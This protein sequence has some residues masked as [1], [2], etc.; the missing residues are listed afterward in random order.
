MGFS[1]FT[2]VDQIMSHLTFSGSSTSVQISLYLICGG[3]MSYEPSS[4]RSGYQCL[5]PA[6]CPEISYLRRQPAAREWRSC[7]SVCWNWDSQVTPQ[8]WPT[9]HSRPSHARWAP[10]HWDLNTGLPLP[11]TTSIDHGGNCIFTL[12]WS[13]CSI[14]MCKISTHKIW[15]SF[16]Y[17]LYFLF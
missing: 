10:A 2:N 11:A 7:G 14:L 13:K 9:V 12:C 1:L 4:W 16:M 15:L 3:G 6:T 17:Y 8:G 5:I